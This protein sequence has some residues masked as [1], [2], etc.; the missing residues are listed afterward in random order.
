MKKEYL[1]TI[2]FIK[3]NYNSTTRITFIY[4]GGE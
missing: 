4:I 2:L 1:K 3:M